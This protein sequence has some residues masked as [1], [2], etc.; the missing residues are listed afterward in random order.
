M[1]IRECDKEWRNLLK[2]NG[3]FLTLG[4]G[5]RG[6]CVSIPE[7][8]FIMP[9]GYEKG[10]ASIMA[11]DKA[12]AVKPTFQQVAR[13]MER[14]SVEADMP[15]E[16]A[17]QEMILTIMDNILSAETPEE[18]FERQE[19]GGTAS[20]DYINKPFTLR[21]EDL[22]WKKSQISG[23]GTF[24]YYAMCQITDLESGRKQTLNG[25][26][27]SFV[28]V[29]SKLDEFGWLDGERVFQLVEKPTSGGYNVILIKPVATAGS[30]KR[31]ANGK[32]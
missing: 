1:S 14:L 9:L 17:N 11:D 16:E 19:A 12:V 29:L 24:P 15:A 32:A 5:D 21:S 18:L 13:L 20:K 8:S 4:L 31:A 22:S 27:F 2:I 3:T 10:C 7:D 25:G 28:S 23:G 26:G 30:A 6:R